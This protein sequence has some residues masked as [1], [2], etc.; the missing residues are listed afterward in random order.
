VVQ[1]ARRTTY[2]LAWREAGSGRPLVLLHAFPVDGRLFGGQLSAAE[3]GRISGRLIAVDLPGFGKTP[4]PSPAPDV[5]TVE[6]LSASVAA[7][8]ERQHWEG[9]LVGGVAIGG[10][11]AIELAARRPDLIGGIVLIGCKPVPDNPSMAP[12]REEVAQQALTEG[13]AAV[14][15]R[16]HAQPLGPQADGAVR[17]KMREMIADADPRGIAGLV[18]GIAR[19]PDPAPVLPTIDVPAQVIAGEAD[20]FSPLDDVKRVAELMPRATL[21]VLK[22]IG[23]MAPL[24][25]PLSVTR[26]LASF[27]KRGSK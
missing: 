20:P 21:V 22:G 11:T 15:D 6:D 5:L 16:L 13:A 23:H 17:A 1:V 8:I 4:Y 9:A 3:V 7:L 25:S 14:A 10:Y 2:D 26:A 12:Q 19:R 27:M 24:E 18:R